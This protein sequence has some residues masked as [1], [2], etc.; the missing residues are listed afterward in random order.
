ME[1][2]IELTTVQ[3]DRFDECVSELSQDA[4]NYFA[5][6]VTQVSQALGRGA[7]IKSAKALMF[8]LMFF[9]ERKGITTATL[10]TRGL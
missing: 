1:N 8:Q 9:T 7:G 5:E 10:L 4:Q 2:D 3:A 6:Q